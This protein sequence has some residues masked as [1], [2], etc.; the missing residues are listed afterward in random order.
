VGSLNAVV[1]ALGVLSTILG[2]VAGAKFFGPDKRRTDADT[3]RVM[4]DVGIV[5]LERYEGLAEYV[6]ALEATQN[7]WIEWAR[8][9]RDVQAKWLQQV[10]TALEDR[11]VILPPVPE[12][13]PV[14]ARLKRPP[15][16]PRSGS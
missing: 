11:G 1:G 3:V 4:S 10:A 12:S 15:R 2:T 7:E 9:T 13:P 5:W 8:I 14:P 16:H 6:D